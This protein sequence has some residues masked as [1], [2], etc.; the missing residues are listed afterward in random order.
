MYFEG[1]PLEKENPD[2]QPVICDCL[3]FCCLLD[4]KTPSNIIMLSVNPNGACLVEV[5]LLQAH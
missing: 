2:N 1:G 4:S 5:I 3:A